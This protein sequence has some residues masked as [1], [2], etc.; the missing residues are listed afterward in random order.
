MDGYPNLEN[1]QRLAVLEYLPHKMN[2]YIE[3][4]W[5]SDLCSII[6]SD[7]ISLEDFSTFMFFMSSSGFF[8]VLEIDGYPDLKNSQTMG[9]TA[10]WNIYLTN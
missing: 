7:C 8:S 10:V 9:K 4:L 5:Y 2:I 1:S 6:H 3:V